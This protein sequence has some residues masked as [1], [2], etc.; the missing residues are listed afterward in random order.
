MRNFA[1]VLTLG[2]LAIIAIMIFVPKSNP[3]SSANAAAPAPFAFMYANP[4]P[5]NKD[6]DPETF[7]PLAFLIK[8]FKFYC[9]RV[10]LAKANGIGPLGKEIVAFCEN[11]SFQIMFNPDTNKVVV[12][13][14]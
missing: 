14:Y 4:W 1:G 11:G 2:I 10:A 3:A 9:P 6:L 5:S 8:E 7:G 13:P 12:I